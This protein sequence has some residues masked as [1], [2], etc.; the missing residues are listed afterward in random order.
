MPTT[1]GTG[2][3]A[4]PGE[5]RLELLE[6]VDRLRL[7]PHGAGL[8]LGW[9]RSISRAGSAAPGSTATPMANAVGSPIELPAASTPRFMPA[10]IRTRPIAS[11][12]KTAVALT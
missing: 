8:H 12:S 7:R 10:T 4:Q 2:A 5:E 6:V 11:T 3:P 9:S 1:S